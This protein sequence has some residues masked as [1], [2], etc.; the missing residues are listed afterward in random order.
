MNAHHNWTAQVASRAAHRGGKLSQVSM[1]TPYGQWTQAVPAEQRG[2]SEERTEGN[3]I[4]AVP[5]AVHHGY[6]LRCDEL[7]VLP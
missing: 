1:S 5:G 2:T 4:E 7:L 3:I 6:T